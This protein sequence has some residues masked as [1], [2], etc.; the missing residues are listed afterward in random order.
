M[1]LALASFLYKVIDLFQI[2]DARDPSIID[3]I[4]NGIGVLCAFD[5]FK[6]KLSTKIKEEQFC[7]LLCAHQKKAS[8]YISIYH[9]HKSLCSSICPYPQQ[10]GKHYKEWL[11]DQRT[12]TQRDGLRTAIEAALA[13]YPKDMDALLALLQAA[14]WEVKCRKHIALRGPGQARFKRLDSL[15]SGFTQD[16]LAARLSAN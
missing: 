15:G 16:D 11:G 12:P 3:Q 7:V 2:G 14:G 8:E 9:V 4:G 6:K 5:I 10:K 1:L 13:Q